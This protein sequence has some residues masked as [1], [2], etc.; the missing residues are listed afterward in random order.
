M[1]GVSSSLRA[2]LPKLVTQLWDSEPASKVGF[3]KLSAP[4]R[5]PRPQQGVHQ[6]ELQRAPGAGHVCTSAVSLWQ[7][8]ANK[9]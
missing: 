3:D 9:R 6:S 4:R 7:L 2:D 8:E 5:H 1:G